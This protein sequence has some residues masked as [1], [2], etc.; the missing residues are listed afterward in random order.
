MWGRSGWVVRVLSG[1]C[2]RE[3]SRV[4]KVGWARLLWG[5][6]GRVGWSALGSLWVSFGFPSCIFRA[7]SP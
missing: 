1:G 3:S 6:L 5:N 4:L 7:F 2:F